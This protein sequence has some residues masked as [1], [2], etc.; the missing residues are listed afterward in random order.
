MLRCNLQG[1]TTPASGGPPLRHSTRIVWGRVKF[2]DLRFFMATYI[3]QINWY[4]SSQIMGFDRVPTLET[5]RLLLLDLL[6][7]HRIQP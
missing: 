4:G 3:F 1:P 5:P 2:K 6:T 7:G